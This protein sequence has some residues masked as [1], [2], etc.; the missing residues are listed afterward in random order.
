MTGTY[1]RAYERD[2]PDAE[3]HLLDA[4]HFA[5]ETHGSEITALIRDFLRRRIDKH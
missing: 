3:L 4:G 5:R 1:P 2:I